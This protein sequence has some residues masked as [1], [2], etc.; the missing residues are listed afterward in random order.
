VAERAARVLVVDDDPTVSDVL[1][2]YLQRDGMDVRLAGDGPGALAEFAAYRPD[3][4]VLDLMLPGIDGI[5]VCRRMRADRDVAVIMLTA[6]GEEADRVLGLSTG[7]DD[8]VTKPFSPR[9]LALRVRSVLRRSYRPEPSDE[10]TA[11]VDGGLAVDTAARIATLDGS[12]L[13]LTVREFDLLAYLMRHPGT[14]FRRAE[15][16]EAVWGWTFGDH[17]TVTVHVRRLREKVE[18]DPTDPTR[19]MTVW[20][21]GYRYQP[22]GG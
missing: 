10:P 6:L 16:L 19:I 15:L 2:R 22:E 17:A 11:L 4:V 21:I 13:S 20:G 7:A 5:E 12:P 18:P 3:L 14:A 1:R 8:Y 9:E